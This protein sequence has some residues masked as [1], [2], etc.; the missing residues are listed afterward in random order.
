M[1]ERLQTLWPA[2]L[3]AFDRAIASGNHL[4]LN[5]DE[6]RF[7][8]ADL[9]R[10]CYAF[11]FSDGA[12]IIPYDVADAYRKIDSSTLQEESKKL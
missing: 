4:M 6:D 10:L 9:Q 11:S 8:F 5:D 2:C 1:F 12:L 7:L 3:S